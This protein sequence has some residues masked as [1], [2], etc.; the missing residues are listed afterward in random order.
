MN[1]IE[2]RSVDSEVM[3]RVVPCVSIEVDGQEV[4]DRL[5]PYFLST[6]YCWIEMPI[7]PK[8]YFLGEIYPEWQSYG[9]TLVLMHCGCGIRECG[10]I[11]CS[12]TVQENKVIWSDFRSLPHCEPI[13]HSPDKLVFDLKHYTEEISK[14]GDF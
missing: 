1:T 13:E 10:A 7:S 9:E 4:H 11:G 14:L 12:I 3:S 8:K 5:N 2:L 6:D